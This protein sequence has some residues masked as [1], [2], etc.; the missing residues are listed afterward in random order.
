MVH[1]NCFHSFSQISLHVV[2]ALK[3]GSS[4]KSLSGWF[5]GAVTR[6]FSGNTDVLWRDVDAT[7]TRTEQLEKDIRGFKFQKTIDVGYLNNIS[8]LC[9]P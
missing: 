3:E 7:D 9:H 1:A 2:W 5:D 4:D 8:R 6:L